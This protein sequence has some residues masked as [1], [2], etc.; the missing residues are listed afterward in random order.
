METTEPPKL[1]VFQES[2]KVKYFLDYDFAQA[3]LGWYPSYTRRIIMTAQKVVK[4]DMR[5]HVDNE[6]N[7]HIWSDKWLLSHP[8]IEWFH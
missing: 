6:D 7:I 3:N 2:L 4:K 5:W 8:H 1:F